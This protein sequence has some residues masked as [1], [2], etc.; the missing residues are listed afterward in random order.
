MR[1]SSIHTGRGNLG[2]TEAIAKKR[3]PKSTNVTEFFNQIQLLR[4]VLREDIDLGYY[5]FETTK[6]DKF[7]IEKVLCDCWL[8]AIM[9]STYFSFEK[10]GIPA[11][12]YQFMVE[13]IQEME[14]SLPNL[15]EFVMEKTA[16]ARE[17]EWSTLQAR[18]C[19]VVFW[20]VCEELELTK[21]L[22][23]DGSNLE[24]YESLVNNA[25][26]FNVIGDYLFSLS[27]FTLVIN[28]GQ[29][30][31]LWMN[32]NQSP[33]DAKELIEELLKIDRPNT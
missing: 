16:I 33:Q 21:G 18:Q 6:A 8:G 23:E 22:R 26:F 12:I 32:P 25:R 20:R 9:G 29:K 5:D 2:Y 1:L 28:L 13:R 4:S 11:E 14:K 27:R 17:L 3:L 10:L 24:E 7:F 15:M 31:E 19:E 30:E